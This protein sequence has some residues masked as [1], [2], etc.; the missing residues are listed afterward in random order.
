MNASA[1]SVLIA[2]ATLL[3]MA[4]TTALGFWQLDRAAQKLALQAHMAAQSSQRWVDT[5]ALLAH[6]EPTALLHQY[7]R[8]RGQ[9]LAE[10][11]LYL[12]NRP[13]QGKV[14]FF[15]VTPLQLEGTAQTVLVLRGWVQ[16]NFEQRAQL[17]AIQTPTGTVT[18]EGRIALPPGKLFE[19]GTPAHTAIR[20]NLDLQQFHDETGLAVLP[21]VLMQSG[22]ASEGLLREWPEPNVGVD[23]HYGYAVQWFAMAAALALLYLWYQILKPRYHRTKDSKPHA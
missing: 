15:V 7:A 20:Q 5:S 6:P 22:P 21:V 14:G 18:L 16:R 23:K 1:R 9:W 12:D 19:L 2:L 8:L 13:M 4:L 3:G 10:R 11:T 17:P